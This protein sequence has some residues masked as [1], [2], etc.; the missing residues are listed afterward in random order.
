[1]IQVGPYTGPSWG[2]SGVKSK[3]VSAV[4]AITGGYTP[5]HGYL[6]NEASGNMIDVIGADNLT[7]VGTLSY[8]QPRNEIL[9][10]MFDEGSSDGFDAASSSVWDHGLD[11]CAAISVV[12]FTE[13]IGA[14]RGVADKGTSTLNQLG[15]GR[16]GDGDPTLFVDDGTA[17]IFVRPD[18]PIP[19]EELVVIVA[20]VDRSTDV[21]AL[22]V[23]GN[24]GTPTSDSASISSI[25]DTSNVEAVGLG[26]ST[27]LSSLGGVMH[28]LWLFGGSDANGMAADVSDIARSVWQEVRR[29]V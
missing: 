13:V 9:G 3:L 28:S 27:Y 19:A 1:M 4:R 20:A 12:T 5:E 14:T 11:S 22:A 23:C 2:P 24:D 25:G 15:I 7:P 17:S 10:I 29:W 16:A 18:R 6:C 26:A 8:R 21:G